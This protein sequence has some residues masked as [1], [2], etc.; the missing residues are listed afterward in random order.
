MEPTQAR[1]DSS[2]REEKKRVEDA[3]RAKLEHL[4]QKLA[5]EAESSKRKLL[6]EE[7]AHK[8]RLEQEEESDAEVVNWMAHI[9]VMSHALR[10][11]LDHG[12]EYLS[13]ETIAE[14]KAGY[15]ECIG[16]EASLDEL[17]RLAP[18]FCKF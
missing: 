9:N 8:R 16:L 1:S 13:P 10:V 15:L 18:N 12:S 14:V 4:K 17:N 2:E 11:T 7:K 6:E 3:H 5:M